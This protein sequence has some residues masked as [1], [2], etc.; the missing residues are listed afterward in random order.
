MVFAELW[1]IPFIALGLYMVA[2]RFIYK[3]ISHGR[4]AYG[5][6]RDRAISG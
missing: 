6:T 1:G 5:V 2:G 4:T 3:R